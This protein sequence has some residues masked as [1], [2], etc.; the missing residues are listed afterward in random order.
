MVN[1]NIT[2]NGFGTVE[3]RFPASDQV[4]G[5]TELLEHILIRMPA[6]D[7]LLSQRVSQ[8]WQAVIKGSLHLQRVLL[9]TG[10]AADPADW[11]KEHLEAS[12]PT[13]AWF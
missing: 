12:D 2:S 6:R 1:S 4:F 13:K 5:T 7:V 8:Q 9:F 3:S 10:E 11:I